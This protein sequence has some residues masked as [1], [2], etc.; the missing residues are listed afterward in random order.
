MG[1][2]TTRETGMKPGE[3][4]EPCPGHGQPLGALLEESVRAV[5]AIGP[6]FAQ[7]GRKLADLNSRWCEGRFHLAVLGQFKRGKSTLLNALTGESIL[8][9][10]VVPLTAA[11]TFI[12]FGASPRIS[13]HYP[14]DRPADEFTGASTAERN[15]FLA[16]FVTEKGNPQ[17]RRGITEVQ[18]E[19]PAPILSGGV[20]LIDTPGIGSTYLHNTTATLNFLQQCDAALF[21]VSADPPITEVELTFLRHVK[22]KVPRLFFVL[23]K[24]DYLDA[25][26][27]EEA[28]AFY[29]DVLREAVGWN[30]EFPVFCVSARKGLE[31]KA[32][33]DSR[34]WA[35]SGMAQ[36]DSFL[37]GFLAREK[38]EALA[39][40]VC[41]RA[42]DFMEAAL[43]E[44]G[45]A[46][47]ALKLPRQEL[48]EKIALFEQSLQRAA[49]ER[50]LIQDVLEGDKKRVTAFVEDQARDLH[51][52]AGQHLQDIMNRGA[53]AGSYGRSAKAGIQQ[54]WAEAI[55]DYFEQQRDALDERVKAQLLECLAPHEQRLAELVETLRHSAAD[56]FRVPYRPL[57]PDDVLEIKRRPYWV[58]STWNTDPLPLLQSMDQRLDGLVR[59]NVENIRWSMLQNL[60]VSFSGFVRRTRERLD[61]TVAATKGAME[62]AQARRRGCAGSIEGE[63][64]RMGDAIAALEGLK[65]ELH[66]LRSGL[67]TAVGPQAPSRLQRKAGA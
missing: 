11:P 27:L 41:R 3:A 5:A 46:L 45:I 25:G 12:Q 50:R 13:V 8:P 6:G 2:K 53:A 60:N 64:T 55:P 36:L 19:L 40:A 57:S 56:L 43:M 21:L 34:G 18:V 7:F 15:A 63:V 33:A 38:F 48:E 62:A 1:L 24:I 58:L 28:L 32:A 26:E 47:Q 35:A 20:V 59:R 49:S 42:L 52:E 9:M 65:S 51:R 37:V 31:S 54:A 14:G 29:Q 16:G 44:A 4:V 17:N 66:L 10:G 61:E 67:G 23:N 30:K 39:D 22:E